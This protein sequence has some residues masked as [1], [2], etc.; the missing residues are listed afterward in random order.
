M[1]LSQPTHTMMLGVCLVL[2][3]AATLRA[4]DMELPSGPTPPALTATHM[5][6]RVHTFVWRNWELVPPERMAKVLGCAPDDVKAVG[7]SM[8]LADAP[9][10]TNDQ[11]QRSYITIIRRNW[12]L[13]PYEQMLTLLD[14]SAH[15]LAYM[16][17]ED[18]FLYVKL[19][20]LKPKCDP[21]RYAPP[22]DAQKA[23]AKAVADIVSETLGT[24]IAPAG[25]KPFAFVEQ[26][27]TIDPDATMPAKTPD[28]GLR[29]R[30][31]YSYF[32]LYGDP[33]TEPDIDPYPEG[34][35][36][37]L[38]A[39]GVNGVWMQAVLNQ[40]APS[41][42]FQEF[43]K[44]CEQRLA[45]LRKL[46][47]RTKKYGIGVYL[48]LNEPRTQDEAFFKRHPDIRGLTSGQQITMCVST[49]KVTRYLG[50]ATEYIF[51]N[52]PDLAGAFTIS[53][54]ENLTNCWS[55]H[56]GKGCPR[57][58]KRPPADVIAATNRAMAEGVHRG[59]PAAKF[60]VWDWGWRDDYV[61]G[62]LS[63]L[64]KDT[65]FMS[66]SEWSLPIERGGIKSRVGE[67]SISAVGPGPRATRHWAIAKKNG[68]KI[69]A[70]MQINNT[71]EMAATPYV[72]ALGLVGKHVGNLTKLGLDGMMLSWTLGGFPS[73]NLDMV[74]ELCKPSP[75]TIDQAME[76]IAKK[77]FGDAAAPSVV[78]A[79]QAFST[80]MTEYP[81]HGSLIYRCAHHWGTANLLY[82]KP[83]GYASTM[84]GIPY[85]DV[86]GWS[87][88]YPPKIMAAQFEKVANGWRK[89]LD[90]LDRAM[91]VVD[92]AR[93]PALQAE[94]RVSEVIRLHT[95]S[96]ANQ[97]RFI[98]ARD[99][100]AAAKSADEKT[101][102][103]E[104]IDRIVREELA[105]AKRHYK[106]A[107]RD[108]R[109][110]YEATNHYWYVPIDLAEKIVNCRFILDDW[111]PKQ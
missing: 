9:T 26:L 70:K 86:K 107:R 87:A 71:W 5:P 23:R 35:L 61:E 100:L 83:T 2:L 24:D 62:I 18:D 20:R 42:D 67:Y 47:A 79:W 93:R 76:R 14:W 85:D 21:L 11:W 78:K 22:T 55:H 4:A 98:M 106:L 92:D 43:G 68:L 57:C 75:P 34:Y 58:G 90:E 27:S 3:A 1:D 56:R 17:K 65:W 59:N 89:G 39:L 51:K 108:S 102:L 105:M 19:G 66:V 73:P 50:E 53:A 80:A 36:Q 38:A 31:L 77:R 72:P 109:I 88:V 7:K 46:A 94:R 84:V 91:A 33:L 95:Q 54:S 74:S 40:L 13:L 63:Q 97:V 29:L 52:V 110:G 82:E 60:I 44:G 64:P 8:G 15:K 25:E 28:T 96:V 99:A 12:H 30:Y 10:V 32:A 41:E 104:T 49:E 81:Y 111:L 16:L 69:V 37:K 6:S 48:Y 103:R 101:A 45:N